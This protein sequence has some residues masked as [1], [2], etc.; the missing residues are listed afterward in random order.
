MIP[1]QSIF[2]LIHYQVHAW[3]SSSYHRWPRRSKC[4]LQSRIRTVHTM[5]YHGRCKF[6]TRDFRG[7]AAGRCWCSWLASVI[8]SW[9]SRFLHSVV[10]SLAS[11]LLRAFCFSVPNVCPQDYRYGRASKRLHHACVVVVGRRRRGTVRTLSQ[12]KIFA[13]STHSTLSFL[14]KSVLEL[15]SARRHRDVDTHCSLVS[16]TSQILCVKIKKRR[17]ETTYDSPHT[18]SSMLS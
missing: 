15:A 1:I 10:S 14:T 9:T 8:S 11:L 4:E 7:S 12:A 17:Y 6:G 2:W 5:S 18:L 16:L 3:H 13:R